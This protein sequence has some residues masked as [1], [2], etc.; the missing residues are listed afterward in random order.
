MF[1]VVGDIG[2][3]KKK[4]GQV[5]ACKSGLKVPFMPL[6]SSCT[7]QAIL[8]SDLVGCESPLQIVH[9]KKGLAVFPSPAWMS[10]TKL[11]LGGNN[12]I[13]PALGEFGQ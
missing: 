10:L 12:L 1:L 8:L 7:L 13:F 9:C 6:G 2:F 5:L 3:K 4:Q 11:L